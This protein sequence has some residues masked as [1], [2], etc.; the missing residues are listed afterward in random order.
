[1]A[2]WIV[3]LLFFIISL[4]LWSALCE[5]RRFIASLN[6][7]NAALHERYIA[8]AHAR[9]DAVEARRYE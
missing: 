5:H 4:L 8:A 3:A 1:M 9:M 2:G 7:R 6:A